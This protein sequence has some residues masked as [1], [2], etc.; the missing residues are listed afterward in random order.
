MTLSTGAAAIGTTKNSESLRLRRH[1]PIAGD[2]DVLRQAFGF[3]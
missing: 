1:K 3:N 2:N